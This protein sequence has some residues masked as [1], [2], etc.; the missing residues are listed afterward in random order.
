MALTADERVELDNLEARQQALMNKDWL[1]PEQRAQY[2]SIIDRIDHLQSRNTQ[3]PSSNDPA[4]ADTPQTGD[5]GDAQSFAPAPEMELPASDEL[6][7]HQPDIQPFTNI[8]TNGGGPD[9]SRP[10]EQAPPVEGVTSFLPLTGNQTY[11]DTIKA[12]DAALVNIN[13]TAFKLNPDDL[14][15]YDSATLGGSTGP[16]TISN[17]SPCVDAFKSLTGNALENFQ[18]IGSTIDAGSDG[19]W[20]KRMREMYS[21]MLAAA[22]E[23]VG[24]GGPAID[25]RN[26]LTESGDGIRGVFDSFRGAITSSRDAIAGLYGVDEYGDRYLD[27]S[28][29]L[30]IDPSI[31]DGAQ[32]Q[33][34]KLEDA[35]TKLGTSL[36]SWNIPTRLTGGAETG[37][38]KKTNTPP[39]GSPSTVSP[40]TGSPSG[41]PSAN[42]PS[43][44]YTP[45]SDQQPQTMAQQTPTSGASMPQMPMPQMPTASVPQGLTDMLGNLNQPQDDAPKNPEETELSSDKGADGKTSAIQSDPTAPRADTRPQTDP[46]SA[47]THAVAANTVPKPGDPVRPGA[48]GADG[49]PLDK[50][51]DGLMDKDAIAATK[52]NADPNGDGIRDSFTV[53]VDNGDRAVNVTL[54]DPRIA[55]MMQRLAGA[56]NEEPLTIYEAAEQSG[57]K[58]ESYGTQIDTL[59]TLPGDIV[60]GT[61]KGIYLGNGLVLCE[62]GEMKGLTEVMNADKSIDKPAVFRMELPELPSTGEVLPP[63]ADQLAAEAAGSENAP[64]VAPGAVPEAA[65]EPAPAPAPEPTPEPTPEPETPAAPYMAPSTDTSAPTDA[66]GIQ[67]VAYQ[68]KALG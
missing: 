25:S 20:M 38:D 24:D 4:A 27:T 57:V 23:G 45:T 10:V 9:L 18:D 61:D 59:A 64:E 37:D 2:D 35:S 11:D 31:A 52:E 5:F 39:T 8:P 1:T 51:G 41:S 33:I 15:N 50:D 21:P 43:G 34:A 46:S 28:R 66:S 63:E 29:S 32:Q 65:P 44:G 17:L 13:D 54:N 22:N 14:W 42:S 36:D 7:N 47:A 48:L 40:S 58:L 53:E 60:T 62:N 6:S 26:L 3:S 16:S 12:V 56:S 67:E 55:E 30:N 68:G 19:T 49:K